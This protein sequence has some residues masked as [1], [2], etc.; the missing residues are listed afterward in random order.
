MTIARVTHDARRIEPTGHDMFID[1]LLPRQL[2]IARPSIHGSPNAPAA[3][4]KPS[5]FST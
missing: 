5:P 1:D 2:L 4:P 3:G